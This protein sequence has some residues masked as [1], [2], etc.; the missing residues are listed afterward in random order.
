MASEGTASKREVRGYSAIGN[1]KSPGAR[2]R[3]PT[4]FFLDTHVSN[5]KLRPHHALRANVFC[6]PR[7]CLSRH[8]PLTPTGWRNS[9]PVRPPLPALASAPVSHRESSVPT[10]SGLFLRDI[11]SGTR[12]GRISSSNNQNY[13]GN[14]LSTIRSGTCSFGDCPRRCRCH[15]RG[16]ARRFNRGGFHCE[17]DL[18]DLPFAECRCHNERQIRAVSMRFGM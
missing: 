4:I 12:Q 8:I 5:F 6:L 13:G 3:K 11:G 18:P 2:W 1:G 16:G 7:I 9:V 10:A 15:P 14:H 17:T